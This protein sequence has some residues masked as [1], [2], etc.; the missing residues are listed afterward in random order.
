MPLTL[1]AQILNDSIYKQHK[2]VPL[3]FNIQGSPKFVEAPIDSCLE[4]DV[5]MLT[6]SLVVI[7]SNLTDSL[8]HYAARYL[9]IRYRY[10][11]TSTS[12]FD[13]SGFTR[14]VFKQ[15]GI[16]LSRSSFDQGQ[17][18]VSINK[19]L[20]RPGD[21]IFFK[22]R[23]TKHNR[24]GH[25]GI[26]TENNNGTLT[27]IHASRSKGISFQTTDNAYYRSRYIGIRRVV[28]FCEPTLSMAEL[29]A[30]KPAEVK[31]VHALP[32]PEFHVVGKGDSLY[33]ISKKYG[34]PVSTIQKINNLKNDRIFPGQVIK[35]VK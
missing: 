14:H 16:E 6:D 8:L 21:L 32:A 9:G 25:V 10:G 30:V 11:G 5:I 12:G 26:V 31:A 33:R 20:A 15:F 24:I 34:V 23:N 18:G 17:Q 2:G 29:A 19:E 7:E 35:L 22:G 27:F 3:P 13:C 4:D 1:S 28:E